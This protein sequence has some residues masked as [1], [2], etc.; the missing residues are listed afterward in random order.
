[1][2]ESIPTTSFMLGAMLPIRDDAGVE[3][4]L[5]GLDAPSLPD[6]E[7]ARVQ[8]SCA[9]LRVAAALT[10]REWDI[11]GTLGVIGGVVVVP[12][13]TAGGIMVARLYRMP[14]WAQGLALVLGI[15]LSGWILARAINW[16]L[17]RSMRSRV[18]LLADAFLAARWCPCCGYP[19]AGREA[20]GSDLVACSECGAAWRSERLGAIVVPT[21][22]PRARTAF[23]AFLHASANARRIS[24]DDGGRP[25]V[26]VPAMHP[27]VALKLPGTEAISSART[28]IDLPLALA[29]VALAAAALVLFIAWMNEAIAAVVAG[30][31]I[32]LCVGGGATVIPF[33]TNL[34]RRAERHALIRRRVCPACR[35]RLRRSGTTMRCRACDAQWSRAERSGRKLR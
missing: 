23:R 33:G 18:T 12:I 17:S 32:A 34:A 16:S 3:R 1:V 19:L 4:R 8:A 15:A 27:S 25:F 24:H 9:R 31:G 35:Q 11:A 5:L 26:P 28:W 21:G 7:H 22:A 6:P 20:Q 29:L 10:P 30:V 14:F 2:N 13:L